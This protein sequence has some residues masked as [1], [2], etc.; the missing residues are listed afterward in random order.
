MGRG[1]E[2]RELRDRLGMNRREFSDYYGIPYR[3]VQDWEAEKRELPEYLLRLMI[4]RAE[5]ERLNKKD[6]V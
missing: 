1:K 4:Y 2:V 5:M 6:E 3:T